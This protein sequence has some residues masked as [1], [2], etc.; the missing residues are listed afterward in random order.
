MHVSACARLCLHMTMAGTTHI[1]STWGT[2]HIQSTYMCTCISLHTHTAS[3]LG[4]R[5]MP[6]VLVER[7]YQHLHKASTLR[8]VLSGRAVRENRAERRNERLLMSLQPN[9]CIHM[10]AQV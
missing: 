5:D 6:Q 1:W 4:E 8:V 3:D 9:I 7:R 10:R 2:T